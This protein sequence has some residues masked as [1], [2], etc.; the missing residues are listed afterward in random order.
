MGLNQR[1]RRGEKNI[2]PTRL[3]SPFPFLTQ[4]LNFPWLNP[5]F[6]DHLI[7]KV[8]SRNYASNFS[9]YF[10]LWDFPSPVLVPV[11]FHIWTSRVVPPIVTLQFFPHGFYKFCVQCRVRPSAVVESE[12]CIIY[13]FGGTVKDASLY[14]N[15]V[16]QIIDRQHSCTLVPGF[17]L[18]QTFLMPSLFHHSLVQTCG[19]CGVS[20]RF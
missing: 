18:A 6:F 11:F 17:P 9:I 12:V 3:Y 1:T 15:Q 19:Q 5:F 2:R 4:E 16:R 10:G 14:E 20:N 13:D 7:S 8:P